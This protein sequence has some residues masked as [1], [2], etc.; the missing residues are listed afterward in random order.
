MNKLQKALCIGTG[1]LA[2]AGCS[3]EYKTGTVIAEY[4]IDT[5]LAPSQISGLVLSGETVKLENPY[6]LQIKT[7]DGVYTASVI[8]EQNV[9]LEALSVVLKNGDEIRFPT[10]IWW[11]ADNRFNK[12]KIGFIYSDEIEILD[13]K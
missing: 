6:V 4:G 2:L 8:R 10:K 1:I 13:Q 11:G 7:E 5:R 9:T 12:N 3:R